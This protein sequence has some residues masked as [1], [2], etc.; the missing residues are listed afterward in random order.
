[1]ETT[2]KHDANMEPEIDEASIK[3][4]CRMAAILKQK[5]RVLPS[6]NESRHF[7]CELPMQTKTFERVEKHDGEHH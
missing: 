7:R 4:R 6:E 2:S 1:M 5:P 3:T